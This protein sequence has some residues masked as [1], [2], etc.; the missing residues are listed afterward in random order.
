[1]RTNTT[2][3]DVRVPV[4][5]ALCL[6]EVTC[7]VPSLCDYLCGIFS[8]GKNIL[9]LKKTRVLLKKKFSRL[10]LKKGFEQKCDFFLGTFAQNQKINPVST[11]Y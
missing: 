7:V 6:E 11:E 8:K 9:L 3:T 5:C 4:W 10:L 1:M 2:V